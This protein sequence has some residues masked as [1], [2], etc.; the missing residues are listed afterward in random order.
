MNSKPAASKDRRSSTV[1][2]S[3]DISTFSQSKRVSLSTCQLFNLTLDINFN[4]SLFIVSG[5]VSELA[6]V[7][8]S[9]SVDLIGGGEEGEMIRA[10]GSMSD[11]IESINKTWSVKIVIE[12]SSPSVSGFAPCEKRSRCGETSFNDF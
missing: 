7:V 3:P 12:G 10:S 4:R 1:S 6:M 2:P 9:D 5:S 11:I 8:I